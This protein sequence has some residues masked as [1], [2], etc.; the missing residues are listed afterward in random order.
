LVVGGR[1]GGREQRYGQRLLFHTNNGV[2]T[3]ETLADMKLKATYSGWDFT[4]TWGIDP[5]V[6][7]GYPYLLSQ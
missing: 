4:N 5:G 6:N 3:A 7:G 1:P 2:G